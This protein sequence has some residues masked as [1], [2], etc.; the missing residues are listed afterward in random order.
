MFRDEGKSGTTLNRPALKELLERAQQ[1]KSVEAV[2]V[3]E[4]DRLARNTKDHLTIRVMLQKEGV[5]LVSVAQPMLDDSPEGKMVD[6]II[7]SVNQFQ[8]DINSRKTMKGM[9]EK[10][11][12]GCWPGW[13]PLGYL[14]KTLVDNRRVIVIDPQ[15]W[16]LV[17][18]GLKMYLSG[19]YSVVEIT[20]ILYKKGLKSKTGKKI[21]NSIM[22]NILKNPFY[23]GRMRW[24]GQ[25]K[26][27]K[28]RAMISWLEYQRIIQILDQ[29]NYRACRRRKHQFLLNGFIFCNI[30]GGRYT[31]EKHYSVSYYHCALNGKRGKDKAHTNQNQNVKVGVLENAVEEKFKE[32][33]FSDD[34]I[35]FVVKRMK[36][37]YSKQKEDL[38]TQK[39]VLLNQKL[40]VERKRDIVEEKLI[41]G[42]ISND[43]F[44]RI[45]DKFYTQLDH[46]QNQ[47]DDLESQRQLDVSAIQEVL[48]WPKM[49]IRHTRRPH[50]P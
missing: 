38:E 13:A 12:S 6:T 25:E 14:N 26:A 28:H 3:Q 44:V 37:L 18:S 2:L 24:F 8:S 1:D 50:T 11:D 22:T 41:D 45:K 17:R 27:G 30:C 4:T 31:A 32:I 16:H 36:E 49:S 15:K 47:I 34:F 21:C 29:R 46:I 7:A 43:D 39:R 33:Q 42:V 5:K 35:D 20:E 48:S 19:N 10:F 23:A 40:A 9:Q